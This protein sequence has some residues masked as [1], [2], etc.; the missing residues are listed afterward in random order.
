MLIERLVDVIFFIS[1]IC[2]IRTCSII[3]SLLDWSAVNRGFDLK[4]MTI[5]LFFTASP[6]STHH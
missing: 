5:K 3:V 1:R 2:F 4:L 6:L